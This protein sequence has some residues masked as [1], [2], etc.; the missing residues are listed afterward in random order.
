MLNG[1]TDFVVIAIL[2]LAGT[3]KSA[4]LN[5]VASMSVAW[6]QAGKFA[7]VTLNK[8]GLGKNIIHMAKKIFTWQKIF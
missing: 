5:E 4:I 1:S 2:G 3:G 6:G 7:E 8:G